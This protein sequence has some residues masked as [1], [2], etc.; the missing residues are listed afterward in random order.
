MTADT[1]SLACL[2]THLAGYGRL[3][4]GG[5]M[6]KLNVF[7]LLAMCMTTPAMAL[8]EPVTINFAARETPSSTPAVS[9]SLTFSFE[10][11]NGG[12]PQLAP[13]TA[14]DLIIDGHVYVPADFETLYSLP[15]IERPREW[16]EYIEFRASVLGK[17]FFALSTQGPWDLRGGVYH[18]ST[19]M[20]HDNTNRYDNRQVSFEGYRYVEI[21]EAGTLAGFGLASLM[22]TL[23]RS[24]RRR[25]SGRAAV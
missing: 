16:S 5:I 12:I 9:G 4:S 8:P 22:L 19:V 7:A 13:V 10:F 11:D 14:V 1:G 20:F 25:S 24:Q 15:M 17:P 18:N 3:A 6:K 21:P 2:R 23:A